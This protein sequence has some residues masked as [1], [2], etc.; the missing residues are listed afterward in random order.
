MDS[1]FEIVEKQKNRK[2]L[3]FILVF[4]I[5]NIILYI[6]REVSVLEGVK[7]GIIAIIITTIILL[8]LLWVILLPHKF[9]VIGDIHFLDTECKIQTTRKQEIIQYTSIEAIQLLFG[10]KYSDG[11]QVNS[12]QF[13]LMKRE[14]GVGTYLSITVNGKP[15]SMNVVIVSTIQ[16]NELR[17]VLIAIRDSYLKIN[18]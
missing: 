13:V 8:S 2:L 5:A 17:A 1:K 12:P 7:S 15:I 4:V 9:K 3:K 16:F 18:E 11:F 14:S 10:A 6:L